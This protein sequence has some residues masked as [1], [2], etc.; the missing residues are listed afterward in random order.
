MSPV[1]GSEGKRSRRANGMVYVPKREIV[2]GVAFE[3]GRLKFAKALPL[4]GAFMGEL[5]AFQVR[6]T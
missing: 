4:A 6:L 3:N 5:Q 1:G 2:R